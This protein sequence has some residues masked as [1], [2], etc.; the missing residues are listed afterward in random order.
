MAESHL[1]SSA[2]ISAMAKRSAAL[3]DRKQ[4]QCC[5]QCKLPHVITHWP[6]S[7]SQDNTPEHPKAS[8]NPLPLNEGRNPLRKNASR[9]LPLVALQ[10]V[11]VLVAI[12]V[13]R[14]KNKV[15]KGGTTGTIKCSKIKLKRTPV[16]NSNSKDI[17]VQ[18]TKK[19]YGKNNGLVLECRNCGDFNPGLLRACTC[20]QSYYCSITCQAQHWKDG[21]KD[22]CVPIN[23]PISTAKLTVQA[24]QANPPFHL[25]C[26]I[27][28][29][30]FE[31]AVIAADGET[32]E[33]I[34]I[35]R[36][37]NDKKMEIRAAEEDLCRHGRNPAALKRLRTGI[38]SPMGFGRLENHRLTPN[39]AL[40]RLAKEWSGSHDTMHRD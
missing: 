25:C 38:L 32:Y 10:L 31:D 33:R 37:I 27:T 35:E 11:L 30:L 26:P 20:N 24:S 39:R 18:P 40:G 22:N 15:T 6:Q 2:V 28:S 21:H 36:W 7:S 13:A 19:L 34:A 3:S 12:A 16:L 1:E 17:K 5:T 29:E 9:Y 4:L 23:I 14:F 8:P